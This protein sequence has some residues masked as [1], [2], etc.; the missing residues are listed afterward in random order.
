MFV[1]K[2]MASWPS[3]AATYPSAFDVQIMSS[4]MIEEGPRLGFVDERYDCDTIMRSDV[5]FK[6]RPTSHNSRHIGQR[7][8]VPKVH[9]VEGAEA[10]SWNDGTHVR[11]ITGPVLLI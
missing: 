10:L 6:H 3:S 1:K 9:Q 8:A 5:E 2:I 11:G 4:H 7:G